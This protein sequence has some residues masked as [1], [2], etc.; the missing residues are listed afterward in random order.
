MTQRENPLDESD[1]KFSTWEIKQ[2]I[3]A[4]NWESVSK[5]GSASAREVISAIKRALRR[6]DLGV[7]Y[8]ALQTLGNIGS[9]LSV[10]YLLE[11][12]D[13]DILIE[14]DVNADM[15]VRIATLQALADADCSAAMIPLIAGLEG[16]ALLIKREAAKILGRLRRTEAVPYL[17]DLVEEEDDFLIATAIEALGQIG[18]KA[19]IDTLANLIRDHQNNP[20]RHDESIAAVKALGQIG[21]VQGIDV[22]VNLLLNTSTPL[23]I[24]KTAARVLSEKCD[25]S[26]INLLIDSFTKGSDE[27]TITSYGEERLAVIREIGNKAIAPLVDSFKSKHAYIQEFVA[28]ALIQLK[29]RPKTTSEEALLAM[30]NRDFGT[31]TRLALVEHKILLQYGDTDTVVCVCEALSKHGT[32]ARATTKPLLRVL[33]THDDSARKA[34]AHAL[35]RIDKIHFINELINQVKHESNAVPETL[36]EIN[37]PILKENLVERSVWMRWRIYL[38]FGKKSKKI[39]TIRKLG[40]IATPRA[41]SLLLIALN[42]WRLSVRI[43]TASVLREILSRLTEENENP[44]AGEGSA[45]VSKINHDIAERIKEDLDR[46][47]GNSSQSS[48]WS[49]GFIK[50][51]E[52]KFSEEDITPQSIGEHLKEM[53]NSSPE[54]FYKS[55]IDVDRWTDAMIITS[56]V[57][58]FISYSEAVNRTMG[59]FR[60]RSI[61]TFYTNCIHWYYSS[62]GST[63]RASVYKIKIARK[64]LGLW[65][66]RTKYA[67]RT[68][69]ESYD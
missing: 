57:S 32:M 60:G 23:D 43:E 1:G 53:Q 50:R 46:Y 6:V 19:A 18:D 25:N 64:I 59:N 28:T 5:M 41:I 54:G 16:E 68:N 45:K 29:W 67:I 47:F 13:S 9:S 62:P 37:E 42:D 27:Y 14:N 48:A 7:V 51:L 8:P 36:A 34:A 69:S 31:I 56:H 61:I 10:E 11:L 65:F 52:N 39:T 3:K 55:G 30:S 4:G 26:T 40:T 2:A 22:L 12:L 66:H 24:Q 15:H 35:M 21:D 58:D 63:T 49:E 44:I 20:N 17:I 38:Y 33:S